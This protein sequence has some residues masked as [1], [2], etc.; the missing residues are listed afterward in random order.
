M[1]ELRNWLRDPKNADLEE[2]YI[3]WRFLGNIAQCK[4]DIRAMKSTK[5]YSNL[6]EFLRQIEYED[7]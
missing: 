6:K 5:E 3:A 7:N 2:R 1:S 4:H